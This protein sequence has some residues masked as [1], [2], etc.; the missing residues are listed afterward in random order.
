MTRIRSSDR[1][2]A[3]VEFTLALL[4]FLML[5]MGVFDLGRGIYEFNGVSQAA[6]EIARVTSVHRGPGCPPTCTS[7]ETLAVIGVQK[8]L[9][10]NLGD[11]SFQCVSEAGVV[12]P[13]AG[14]AP[15]DG[16]RVT[17][18]A[19]YTA[20]TPLLGLANSMHPPCTVK[21]FACVQGSSTVKIQ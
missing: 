20:L 16:V 14:C 9:V 3:L 11:L 1:G 6:R 21:A 15:G 18:F 10:P 13:D 7:P 12:K 19:P 5:I 4:V 8:N 2:Q 17:A